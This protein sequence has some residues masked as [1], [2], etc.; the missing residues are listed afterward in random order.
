MIGLGH[1]VL[2]VALNFFWPGHRFNAQ[3]D[4]LDSH[5]NNDQGLMR[6]GASQH[7]SWSFSTRVKL[8]VFFL[9]VE[10]STNVLGKVELIVQSRTMQK[11][12]C[13][14]LHTAQVQA[15]FIPT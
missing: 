10:S 1:A 12:F 11:R 6:D 13:M 14:L 8:R 3:C 4:Q 2:A 9:L 15:P 7:Y 5:I